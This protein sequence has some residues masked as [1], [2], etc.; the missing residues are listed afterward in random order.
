MGCRCRYV[1]GRYNSHR[2][3]H[4]KH[5]CKQ[6]CLVYKIS[7][8]IDFRRLHKP[9]YSAHPKTFGEKLR[10]W[11]IDRGLFIKDLAKMIDVTPDTIINWEKRNVKPNRKNLEKIKTKKNLPPKLKEK[12]PVKNQ[13]E[14]YF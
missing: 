5:L 14:V 7:K 3:S 4:A 12:T 8:S 6:F 13:R 2:G 9:S 10:K 11:R 1:L